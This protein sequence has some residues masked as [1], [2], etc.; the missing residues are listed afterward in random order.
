MSSGHFLAFFGHNVLV[1]TPNDSLTVH[2]ARAHFSEV[3]RR[4]EA[5]ETLV[6]TR[7]SRPVVELRPIN[8]PQV[9]KIGAFDGEFHFEVDAFA[10]LADEELKRW[11]V[12]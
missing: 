2:E 10:P 9:R 6:V 12:E 5:G 3:L 11:Y 4:V 7:H 8:K 1:D